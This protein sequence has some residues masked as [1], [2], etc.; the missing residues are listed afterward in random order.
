MSQPGQTLVCFAVK[1]ELQFFASSAA[2]QKTRL[3]LTGI[4]RRNATAAIDRAFAQGPAPGL[5]LS[6]G[7]A[8]GLAPY[9]R[10]GDIVFQADSELPLTARL[11][12][13]GA[14][15]AVFFCAEHLI[16][17]ASE[18]RRLRLE[19]GAD[20]VEMESECI[21]EFCRKASVPSATIRVI[22][23]TADEDLPFDFTRLSRPD[24]TVGPLQIALALA[25]SPNKLGPLLR[26]TRRS[27]HCARRLAEALKLNWQ[28]AGS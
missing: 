20:A 1:E 26:L 22:L 23:D 16:V 10:T 14:K 12:A 6:T 5:V 15:P 28:E 17:T 8:G 4:G 11:A 3:L 18:K 13:K 19:T 9:L 2:A 21:R 24:G 7:F 27:I 25:R